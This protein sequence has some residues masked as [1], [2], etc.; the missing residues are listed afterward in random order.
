MVQ[1]GI[2]RNRLPAAVELRCT[3]DDPAVPDLAQKLGTTRSA[4]AVELWRPH[5][6]GA[7]VVIGNAP[8]ALF[9]LLDRLATW[10]ERPALIL[11]LP[12]GFVGAVE[13][14]EALIDAGLDVPYLTLRG[15]RGGS[16]MA[17]A[18][19]NALCGRARLD[20]PL[21]RRDRH[22]RGRRRQGSRPSLRALIA[23][24]HLVV[25]GARHLDLVADLV[26]GEVVAWS[27]PIQAT[28]QRLRAQRGLPPAVVLASGDPLWFGVGRLLLE[29]FQPRELAFHPHLSAFQ[30]AA[31]R[32][33]W[34]L[35]ETACI[36]LHG[37]AVDRLNRYL[38]TG[39]RLLILT[40]DGAAPALIG[41]RLTKAGFGRSSLTVMESL[42]GVGETA[43]GF[44]A[45]E[46]STRRF[47]D[48]N[49]LA[50]TLE[51]DDPAAARPAAS[52]GQGLADA[53]FIHDGQMTKQEVRAVTMAKLAPRPG[54]HLW[55]IGAG[56]GSIAI[57]W[58]LAGRAAPDLPTT[59]TAL[60]AVGRTGRRDHRERAPAGRAG[61]AR[62]RG[63]GARA[64]SPT[65]P[66]PTPSSSAAGSPH[67]CSS[68]PAWSAWP[69]AAASSSTP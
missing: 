3:L 4:A 36:S 39:R 46:A 6:D 30:L 40:N 54:E 62:H 68:R 8:T 51:A 58:L 45:N 11:G 64:C 49:T 38:A 56:A 67:R 32:L 12:V 37:R 29:H 25:G 19:V 7:V 55:D 31:S 48:L 42:G 35:A 13:S 50:V 26:Q 66:I 52:L 41:E 22:G 15:R 14:K 28:M 65:A 16:A 53:A 21:A 63:Q 10:P 43:I 33:G 27:S 69:S 1:A 9:H 61:A 57:E 18:A 23:E 20:Q 59:A 47:G 17:A 44:P 24:A 5:L 34:T 2:I 60:E